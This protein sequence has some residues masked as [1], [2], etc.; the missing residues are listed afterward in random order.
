LPFIDFWDRKPFGLFLIYAAIRAFGGDG[1]LAYQIVAT[2]AA[3]ST[4]WCVAHIARHVAPP[5]AAIFAGLVYIVY[6]SVNGGDGGQSPV[7]YNLPVALAAS[8]V[9]AVYRRRSFDRTA[10]GLS[11][12]A[13]ALCGLALQIK[14]S[15]VFEGI[16]FGLALVVRAARTGIRLPAVGMAA[17]SWCL[18]ALLPTAAVV[19]VYWHIGALDTLV[20]ANFRSV[21]LRQPPD[22]ALM[23]ERLALIGLHLLPIAI[24]AA[25]A[26]PRLRRVQPVGPLLAGWTA[27]AIA[28]LL[29][30]G[31]Y[32][33]HYAL[34]LVLPLS[35]L[36]APLLARRIGKVPVVV[37]VVLA[38]LVYVAINTA[39]LR[40]TRGDGEGVRRLAARI[41]RSPLGCLFV[42]QGDP[43]LYQLTR[44]CVLTAYNFPTFLSET[45]DS[46]TTGI[47]PHAELRRVMAA[48]PS[49]VVISSID[50]AV[51]DPAAYAFV[52]RDLD[53]HY[54]LVDRSVLSERVDRLYA[55]VA[56]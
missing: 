53:R 2:L 56:D 23:I 14:Y 8:C 49:Y 42:F 10:Y 20:F 35:I 30:F 13:M 11:C 19:G 15:V 32:F 46:R 36:A 1:I 54:R 48:R 5:G 37:P 29:L 33:D 22:T 52:Q 55:R 47:D 26:L 34:P 25:C 43:I 38:G 21:F 7:F 41:G 6:L 39:I 45:G 50:P 31:T 17:L 44:S 4:A 18:I 51:T 12:L 27:A 28:G 9:V 40:T 16:F 24:V 3:A